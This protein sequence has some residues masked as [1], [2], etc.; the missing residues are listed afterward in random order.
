MPD[1]SAFVYSRN[2]LSCGLDSYQIQ[3]YPWVQVE[4]E[5]SPYR[6]MK[7]YRLHPSLDRV[8]FTAMWTGVHFQALAF[9]GWPQEGHFVYLMLIFS[10]CAVGPPNPTCWVALLEVQYLP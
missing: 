8:W 6:S 2:D 4:E 3:I 10:I 1:M 9:T 7:S 5:S